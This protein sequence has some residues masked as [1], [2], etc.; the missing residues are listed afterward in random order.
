MWQ[1]RHGAI[2]H[3]VT[4]EEVL[5][6]ELK[7][8]LDLEALKT[9]EITEFYLV[10]LLSDFHKAERSFE[11]NAG[12]AFEKPLAILFM[13]ALEADSSSRIHKLRSL[14][15]TVLIFSGLFT[16]RVHR[17]LVKLPY[18]V[19]IGGSAYGRLSDL[20]EGERMFSEL[21]SELAMKF[22]DFVNVLSIVAPWNR[23]AHSNTDII[24]A[25]ERWLTSGDEKLRALLE[26]KGVIIGS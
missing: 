23:N 14:G 26:Q 15:D 3:G 25:Y 13:E 7:R 4:I 12:W 16:D 19:S 21:Y 22:A 20:L 9:N 24:R 11:N 2:I 17:T 6:D 1:M 5:R 18:Y 10:N 8:A